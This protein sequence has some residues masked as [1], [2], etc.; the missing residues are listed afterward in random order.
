MRKLLART[1]QLLDDRIQTI[2]IGTLIVRAIIFGVVTMILL[3]G[4]RC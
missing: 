4:T 2:D 1:K 3:V